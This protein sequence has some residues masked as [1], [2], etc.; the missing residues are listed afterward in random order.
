MLRVDP[1]G[2]PLLYSMIIYRMAKFLAKSLAV[3]CARDTKVR[4]QHPVHNFILS[5][6][7]TINHELDSHSL[8]IA[9]NID[10]VDCFGIKKVNKMYDL[11]I[12]KF[13]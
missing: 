6:C 2:S 5:A 9:W 3:L 1:P 10:L 8:N 12:D 11:K 4:V 7:K 13:Y